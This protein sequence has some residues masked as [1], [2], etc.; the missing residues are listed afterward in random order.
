MSEEQN[1]QRTEQKSSQ[2]SDRQDK[3]NSQASRTGRTERK[4]VTSKGKSERSRA[5]GRHCD[6]DTEQELGTT[7]KIQRKKLVQQERDGVRIRDSKIEAE[8]E[9]GIVRKRLGRN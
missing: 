6:T 2:K 1:S 8:K 4:Y 7:R 5:S 9:K 3:T